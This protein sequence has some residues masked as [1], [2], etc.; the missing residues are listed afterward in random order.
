MRFANSPMLVS[1]F[2]LSFNVV[3]NLF[4]VY[5]QSAMNKSDLLRAWQTF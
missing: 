5:L 4:Q 1:C 2:V 3:S